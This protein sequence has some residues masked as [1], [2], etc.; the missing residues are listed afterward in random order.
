MTNVLPKGINIVNK[1]QSDDE[2]NVSPKQSSKEGPKN[3]VVV[4]S[5]EQNKSVNMD[6]AIPQNVRDLG[7]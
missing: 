4:I 2:E 1:D 7:A 5:N 3:N 6:V